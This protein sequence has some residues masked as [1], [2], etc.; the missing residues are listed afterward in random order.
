MG[1]MLTLLEFRLIFLSFFF[2]QILC[3]HFQVTEIMQD[4]PSKPTQERIE[5]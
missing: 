1:N 4:L 2:F 5:L 3:I